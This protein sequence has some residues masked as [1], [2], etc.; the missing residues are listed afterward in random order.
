[1]VQV[2]YVI[3]KRQNRRGPAHLVTA[4]GKDLLYTYSQAQKDCSIK[5]SINIEPNIALMNIYL[6]ESKFDFYY[7]WFRVCE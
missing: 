3:M 2:E 4:L 6:N 7:L 1:M 5:V